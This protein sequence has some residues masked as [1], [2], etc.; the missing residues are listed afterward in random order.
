MANHKQAEKRHRQSVKRT[1]RNRYYVVTLRTLLKKARG[2]VAG[3]AD[4]APADASAALKL[5]DR[6]AVKGIIPKGRAN[7]LKS[8]LAAQAAR[9]G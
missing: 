9:L 4:S 1:A 3:G 8:R 6:V 5:I 2:A 7:R